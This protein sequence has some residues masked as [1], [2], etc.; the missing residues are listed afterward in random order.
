MIRMNRS[1]GPFCRV[2]LLLLAAALFPAGAAAHAA[3][4]SAGRAE[5]TAAQEIAEEEPDVK[6]IVL[7]H[8]GDSYEWHIATAGGREWSLPLPVI[9][10]S[11]SSGW[12]CFS[13]KRLRGGA[14]YEGLRIAADGDHAGKIV[15]RQADGSDLRPLDLSITK[16]VAGLLLNSALVVALVLGAARWYRGRKPDAAAPRGVVGLFETLVESLVDDLIEPCVG[17]SYRR[18]APYLLTVFCFIFLNN[19]MGLIPFFPGGANVTGNIAVA[20]VLAVATFLV[21]NLS[22]RHFLARRADVAQGSRADHS[23]HRAGGRLHQT[24][25][26]DDP[27]VRQH[28]GRARR[29]SEPDVRGVRHGEN[30]R[31]GECF[32][33]GAFGALLDLHELSRAARGVPPGLCLHDALGR[34]HRTG[35]GARRR[36]GCRSGKVMRPVRLLCDVAGRKKTIKRMSNV[37]GLKLWN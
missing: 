9:V 1:F 14:E 29:D 23:A 28:A 21:V 16:T 6:R 36:G 27:S 7:G 30:G 12:H 3:A 5:D 25:R 26:A 33:D 4:S 17:P 32:D 20:L 22:G 19:L 34:L 10:H 35:A 24:L 18:F 37:N 15:E 31:G 8:V 13:A 2:L 11:P